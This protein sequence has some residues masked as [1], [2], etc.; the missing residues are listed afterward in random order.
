MIQ[1]VT[2]GAK[3]TT[4]WQ[5][6]EKGIVTGCTV[7]PI[8]F[9]MGMNLAIEATAEVKGLVTRQPPKRGFVDDL[10][11]T[12]ISH[13]EVRSVLKTLDI[14]GKDNLEAQ[15]VTEYGDKEGKM[16]DNFKL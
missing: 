1:A 10:T 14:I 7:S 11:I 3:F 2:Q 9:I 8:L 5:N 6:L 16:M 12:T 15:E 4:T 13:V